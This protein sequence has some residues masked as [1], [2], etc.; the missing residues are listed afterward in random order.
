M[1]AQPRTP[2]ASREGSRA[3]GAHSYLTS[4]FELRAGLDVSLVAIG[5]LPAEVLRE[6]NRLRN[7][8]GD[9]PHEGLPAA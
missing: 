4:S 3:D 9:R 5:Q 1:N 6:L 7:C 8:W 2:P